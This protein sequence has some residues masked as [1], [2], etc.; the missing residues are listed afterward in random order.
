VK[1][2]QRMAYPMDGFWEG[3][4]AF[5]RYDAGTEGVKGFEK[6]MANPDVESQ[7][8]VLRWNIHRA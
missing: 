3:F 2:T 4:M 7:G 8:Q 6:V 5:M 1:G